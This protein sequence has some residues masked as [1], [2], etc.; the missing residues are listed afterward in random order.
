MQDRDASDGV[1]TANIVTT[2]T[3]T[4][5]GSSLRY[6]RAAPNDSLRPDPRTRQPAN[7]GRY[8]GQYVRPVVQF[9][10]SRAQARRPDAFAGY[11]DQDGDQRLLERHTNDTGSDLRNSSRL[12]SPMRF[13]RQQ[14]FQRH[15]PEKC[16]ISGRGMPKLKAHLPGSKRECST[17]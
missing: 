13:R 10:A 4:R 17:R 3:A 9:A 7:Y 2:I 16:R 8:R 14:K 15:A 5:I 11:F 6:Q 12:A 1:V